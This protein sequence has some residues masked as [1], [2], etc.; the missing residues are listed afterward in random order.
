MLLGTRWPLGYCASVQPERV[1]TEVNVTATPS[2]SV[3]L[4][5]RHALFDNHQCCA[6]PAASELGCAAAKDETVWGQ[7]CNQRL[8]SLPAAGAT[9]ADGNYDQMAVV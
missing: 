8:H 3:W 5:S 7:A 9:P 6:A 1:L 2:E 4:Q